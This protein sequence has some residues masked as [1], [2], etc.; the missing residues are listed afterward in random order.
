MAAMGAIEL[1]MLLLLFAAGIVVVVSVVAAASRRTAVPPAPPRP[2]LPPPDPALVKVKDLAWDSREIDTPLA[3]ALIGYLNEHER[4]ADHQR[5]RNQ[6]SEIAW[7]HRGTC[8]NLS[9]LVLRTLRDN[10]A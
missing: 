7:E 2:Q 4:D 8:P 6:V 10:G 3:D 9:E 5:V 1:L